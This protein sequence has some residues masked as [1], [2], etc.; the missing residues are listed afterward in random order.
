[1]ESRQWTGEDERD[2]SALHLC[3]TCA[4][5]L[6]PG[7]VSDGQCARCLRDAL[8]RAADEEREIA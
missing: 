3:Q 1:M 5:E 2:L 8:E 7:E 4:C 6:Y